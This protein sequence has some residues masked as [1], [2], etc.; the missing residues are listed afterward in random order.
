MTKPKHIPFLSPDP[1]TLWNKADQDRRDRMR[2]F[3]EI[4]SG[5]NPL[6][7]EECARMAAKRPEYA[8][9]AA[10]GPKTAAE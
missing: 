3:N 6:T 10:F 5:P 8:F 1:M 7:P 2:V 4:M 9:M